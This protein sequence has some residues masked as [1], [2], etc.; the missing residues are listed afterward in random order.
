VFSVPTG[1]GNDIYGNLGLNALRGQGRTA[2]LE[3]LVVQEL[4]DQRVAWEP[5]S[6][7]R[8]DAFN[9]WNHTQFRGDTNTG[10]I[11]L[12]A[13]AG[14]FGAITNAFDPRIPTWSEADLLN[15]VSTASQPVRGELAASGFFF[16]KEDLDQNLALEQKNERRLCAT[17]KRQSKKIIQS[18]LTSQ[19]PRLKIAASL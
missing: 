9:T 16:L 8:A 7:S 3:S 5:L 17:S 13:G 14:N 12:N 2:E 11:S 19:E 6:N 4:P 18:T 15:V 1:V 10:G